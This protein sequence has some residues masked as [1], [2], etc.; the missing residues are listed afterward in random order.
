[1]SLDLFRQSSVHA[2]LY[3]RYRRR[4]CQNAAIIAVVWKKRDGKEDSWDQGHA[5]GG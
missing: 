3:T 1:M 2:E 5:S 4:S